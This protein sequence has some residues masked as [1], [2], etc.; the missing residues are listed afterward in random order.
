MSALMKQAYDI[1]ASTDSKE[2]HDAQQ[3]IS[4]T[5]GAGEYCVDIN[6]VRE[7][8]G[9]TPVTPLPNTDEYMLGVLNLR[10]VIVPIFD[11]RCR[12]N[13]GRILATPLHV[14]IVVV[15]GNRIIGI[16]VDAVSD[17]LT[18]EPADVQPVPELD[19]RGDRRFLQ[20]LLTHGEKMIA[21]LNLEQLFELD[22]NLE[23][24]RGTAA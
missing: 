11:L 24:M 18:V 20:A 7:I 16:L 1:L 23:N 19:Q 3:Y 9:W 5:V 13:M 21:L 12:F 22:P 15:I 8:K 10:G 4:F 2:G 14:V 17:I 6:A